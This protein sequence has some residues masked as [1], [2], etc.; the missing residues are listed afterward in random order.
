MMAIPLPRW[1]LLG[2]MA[3]TLKPALGWLIPMLL[4]ASATAWLSYYYNQKANTLL[5][6]QQQKNVDLQQFR[7]SGSKLEQSLGAL[8]D[9]LALEEDLGPAQREMRTAIALNLADAIAVRHLLGSEETDKYIESLASL[10]ETV[11]RLDTVESG[12]VLW[13][14]SLYL[15]DMRRKLLRRAEQQVFSE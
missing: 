6:I 10:R 8:S 4:T 5:V 3:S 11:D 2:Y 7:A 13:R 15:I 12:A 9:A 1:P 14:Q